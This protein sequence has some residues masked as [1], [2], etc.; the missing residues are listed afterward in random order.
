MQLLQMSLPQSSHLRISIVSP[1]CLLHK[2][3]KRNSVITGIFFF[4]VPPE[5]LS[6][7]NVLDAGQLPWI[8]GHFCFCLSYSFCQPL[9]AQETTLAEDCAKVLIIFIEYR[10]MQWV[11]PVPANIY[12]FRIAGPP[13]VQRYSTISSVEVIFVSRLTAKNLPKY[14][15]YRLVSS[16]I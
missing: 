6:L 16:A 9:P 10:V 7:S 1:S 14:F 5:N 2:S 12:S 3:Q 11:Q 4:K 8:P 15:F 13:D